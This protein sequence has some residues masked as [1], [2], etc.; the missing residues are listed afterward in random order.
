MTDWL[1][2]ELAVVGPD[3]KSGW[4]EQLVERR[5][6]VL[7]LDLDASLLPDA[8][9]RVLARVLEEERVARRKGGGAC[10]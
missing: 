3:T 5:A 6:G 2:D 9:Q 8:S 10:L 4:I 1:H 7:T